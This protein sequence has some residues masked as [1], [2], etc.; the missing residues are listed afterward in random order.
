M[1]RISLFV[2]AGLALLSFS[3][4]D[5]GAGASPSG[6]YDN[7]VFVLNEGNAVS[8]SVTFLSEDL[9][10]VEQGI[11][12]AVNPAQTL[13]GYLQSVFFYGDSA[14]VISNGSNKITVVNRY[15]FEYI[16]TIE[17]GLSVP[18]YG[19]ADAGKAYVTNLGSFNDTTDDFVAVIDLQSGT[20]QATWPIGDLADHIEKIGEKLFIANGSFG[21]GD[22]VTVL[23]A[24]TGASL[25]VIN[26]GLAP[27]S[28]AW[29][30]GKLYVLCGAFATDGVLHTINPV[31]LQV[32]ETKEL[33]GYSDPQY[34]AVDSD[35]AYFCSGTS[36]YRL[37]HD[38]QPSTP[39]I[40]AFATDAMT[41]YGFTVHDGKAYVA[42]ARDFASNGIVSVYNLSTGSLVTNVPAGIAP[43][44]FY[45]ND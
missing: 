26:T 22:S 10:T 3:C 44:G 19:V 32:E 24:T 45:F 34:L 27:N 2:M 41:V 17:G 1:K 15:T 39:E 36:F 6:A 21:A 20:V 13:G 16:R 29:Y 11:F 9:S 38:I 25:G 23:N 35:G 30:D 12:A 18:R 33:T 40:E 4:S 28:M 43:N 42:D 5:D 37:W 7:G 31:S 14:Y 8:G